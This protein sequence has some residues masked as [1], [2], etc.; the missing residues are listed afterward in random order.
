M[1]VTSVAVVACVAI[2][3]LAVLARS[4]IDHPPIYDELLHVL[5]ARGI[6]ETGSPSVADGSYSR[7]LVYS[8]AVALAFEIRGDNLISARLPALIAGLLLVAVVSGWITL[9]A[10]PV[11]GVVT[12]IILAISPIT[13]QMSVFARFYTFHALAIA[14]AVITA[15]E[16]TAPTRAATSR[17]LLAGLSIAAVIAAW[18]LQEITLIAVL[19]LVVGCAL[20]FWMARR[21]AGEQLRHSR[22]IG[23]FVAILFAIAVFGWFFTQSSS[24]FLVASLWAADHAVEPRYYLIRGADQLPLL[25]P[26][27]PALAILTLTRWKRLGA[28]VA[29]LFAVCLLAQS[30]AAQKSMRYLFYAWPFLCA[31]L[32]CGIAAAASSGLNFMRRQRWTSGLSGPTAFAVLAAITILMS[33]EGQRTLKWLSGDLQPFDSRAYETDWSDA[34][35]S[36]AFAIGS[37]Q[38]LVT[39]NSMKALYYIGDYDYEFNPSVV[40]ETRSGEEFGTDYRTGRPVIGTVESLARVTQDGERVLVLVERRKIVS[41]F[42]A[43]TGIV[44]W[45]N[46]NCPE[47]QTVATGPLRAWSCD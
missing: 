34:V 9:R 16:A 44:G 28:Y 1:R 5:A 47:L 35:Q 38:V 26:L 37:H 45:L 29:A 11:P 27:A 14:V 12:G 46:N 42:F 23:P 43:R 36:L 41:D 8:R 22:L 32:G 21:D 19:G 6:V 25:W 4:A 24:R 33:Q 3:A 15:F 10:G 7:A 13:V 39:S 18:Q 2:A 31:V 30:I 17:L 40:P 20:T